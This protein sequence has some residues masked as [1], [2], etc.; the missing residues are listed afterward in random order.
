MVVR[1]VKLRLEIKMGHNV[2]VWMAIMK[3]EIN[4]VLSA[5]NHALPVLMVPQTA[6]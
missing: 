5:I 3:L 4:Y 6:A 1:L 2:L